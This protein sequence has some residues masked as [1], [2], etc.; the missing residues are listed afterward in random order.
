MPQESISAPLDPQPMSNT[1]VFHSLPNGASHSA[2]HAAPHRYPMSI[3]GVPHSTEDVDSSPDSTSV[4]SVVDTTDVAPRH[5]RN[6]KA[7]RQSART[8][9]PYKKS[10]SVQHTEPHALHR[11]KGGLHSA[12]RSALSSSPSKSLP[13]GAPMSSKAK[14]GQL[15]LRR[16]KTPISDLVLS[17][18]TSTAASRFGHTSTSLRSHQT[19]LIASVPASML[20][21]A[22]GSTQ[23]VPYSARVTAVCQTSADSLSLV[24]ADVIS[25]VLL[26]IQLLS[27]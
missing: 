18:E 14:S 25:P 22:L 10:A 21:T 17:V 13:I 11:P 15:S 23:I 26:Q 20:T 1:P 2:S 4:S 8:S 19:S 27:K 24:P 7:Q 9:F 5:A 6:T 12:K 3:T 16:K